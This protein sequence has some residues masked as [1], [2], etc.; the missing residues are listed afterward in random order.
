[1]PNSHQPCH[2]PHEGNALCSVWLQPKCIQMKIK[3]TSHMCK[4][5]G[6][7]GDTAA[8]SQQ[9]RMLRPQQFSITH[10]SRRNTVQVTWSAHPH[11]RNTK[12]VSGNTIVTTG[13]RRG[14]PL[15]SYVWRWEQ[16]LHST[17][18]DRIHQEWPDP[19]CQ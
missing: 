10:N 12:Q 4:L 18:E 13:A 19:E 3:D 14:V 15:G 5:W 8:K 17:T 7:G 1:M 11:N 9:M 2:F 16:A 6:W